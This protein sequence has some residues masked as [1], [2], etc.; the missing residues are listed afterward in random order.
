MKESRVKI[1]VRFGFVVVPMGVFVTSSVILEFHIFSSFMVVMMS[2]P[3][4]MIVS[5]SNFASWMVVDIALMQNL[6]L[7]NIET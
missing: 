7:Y 6:D 5:S 3:V 2:V 4:I 1:H